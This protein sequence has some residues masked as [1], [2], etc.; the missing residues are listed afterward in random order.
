LTGNA[1][2]FE[3]SEVAYDIAKDT[4]GIASV[5][6]NMSPRLIKP[7]T[8]KLD[9]DG[10]K[11]KI[12][13]FVPDSHSYEK[14]IKTSQ[15]LFGNDKIQGDLKVGAGSPDDWDQLLDTSMFALAALQQGRVGITD[16]AVY[17]SG[18]TPYMSVRDT[19]KTQLGNYSQVNTTVHIVAADEAESIC[20]QK[21]NALLAS[22]RIQFT[23]NKSIISRNS[24]GLLDDLASVAALCPSAHITIEGHTDSLGSDEAN[25]Q[26][27]Q[28][29]A[30][31]IVAFLF[32]QGIALE[33]LTSIGR[34]EQ[35]PIANNTT[36]HGRSRN[37]R[38]EFIVKP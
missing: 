3:A 11:L 1:D 22:N 35:K 18:K 20:Q 10:N 5:K 13:G 25:N 34:G 7:Y 21:F 15:T 17:I 2:S 33:R 29:R 24:Y 28:R 14:F 27:S 36:E 12:K 26:L 23:A 4:S 30:Q 38:I 16:K 32:Q 37:R 8:M 9:W 6:N 19:I 31:S